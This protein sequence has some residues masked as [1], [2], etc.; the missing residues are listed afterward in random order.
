[1]RVGPYVTVLTKSNTKLEC[2]RLVGHGWFQLCRVGDWVT[3]EQKLREKLRKISALFEGAK[4]VGERSAAAAAILRVK[5]ALALEARTEPLVETRFTLPD[6]WQR[7]LLAALCRRYGL[8]PYRYKGQR[9]TTVVVRAPR[10]FVERTLWPEYWELKQALDEYLNQAT[11][12]II[13]EEVYR[14]A[15]E[16]PERTW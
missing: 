5:Q 15:R 8:E 1:V 4:T 12:R 7:R 16:A 10:S 3:T 6:R 2:N 9:H 14:D 13:R 11:D